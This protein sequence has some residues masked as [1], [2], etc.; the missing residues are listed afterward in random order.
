MAQWMFS[1]GW[2][3]GVFPFKIAEIVEAMATLN[4][5]FGDDGFSMGV[6]GAT[7]RGP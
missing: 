4:R 2:Y 5:V 1:A 6:K 7:A 3:L